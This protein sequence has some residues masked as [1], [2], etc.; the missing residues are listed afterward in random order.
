MACNCAQR[1]ECA[2]FNGVQFIRNAL[3]AR[4]S[5]DCGEG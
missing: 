1:A 5:W 2:R 4:E 3:R